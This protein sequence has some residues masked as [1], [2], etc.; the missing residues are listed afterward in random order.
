LGARI[1]ALR[2]ARR[3]PQK[4][5]A[6]VLGIRFQQL[7]KYESGFN[8]PPAEMLVKLAD[9]LGTSVDYLLTG[10][11][12]E[13]SALANTRLFKRFQ[14]LESLAEEDQQTVIKVIDAM[15]AKRRMT[16]A[17]ASV[18]QGS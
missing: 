11:A 12:A 16:S 2:K 1:K 6:A 10:N 15:I 13:E 8:M 18:D 5:L 7:N 17:L 14:V 3:W 9:A 4:E